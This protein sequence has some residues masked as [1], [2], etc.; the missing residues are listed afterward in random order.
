MT[1]GGESEAQLAY[2]RVDLYPTEQFES[3]GGCA[4]AKLDMVYMNASVGVSSQK[5]TAQTSSTAVENGV[6]VT[7]F[8]TIQPAKCPEEGQPTVWRVCSWQPDASFC[9]NDID[10]CNYVGDS[11]DAEKHG[12]LVEESCQDFEEGD[13]NQFLGFDGEGPQLFAMELVRCNGETP[14]DPS[15]KPNVG[16]LRQNYKE[17]VGSDFGKRFRLGWE[18]GMGWGAVLLSISMYLRRKRLQG[19]QQ[20]QQSQQDNQYAAFEASRGLG[21]GLSSREPS[22]RIPLF[23]A[24]M[25]CA[26]IAAVPGAPEGE[27]ATFFTDN[28]FRGAGLP[29]GKA[30]AAAAVAVAAAKANELWDKHEI[31]TAAEGDGEEDEDDYYYPADLNR[32]QLLHKNSD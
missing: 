29:G 8:M 24:E 9:G 16:E 12:E 18:Y 26:S 7:L 25:S 31:D 17:A 19:G 5:C 4:G 28:P 10:C 1:T 27:M 3:G 32:L 6:D 15:C 14:V 13:C 22:E 21:R 2:C 11:L 20:Q 30:V 23:K